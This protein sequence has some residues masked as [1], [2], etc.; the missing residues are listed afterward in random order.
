MLNLN[1]NYIKEIKF[2][3][4]ADLLIAL[5]LCGWDKFSMSIDYNDMIFQIVD[6]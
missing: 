5:I 3:E 1:Y 4:A 2:Y 6:G